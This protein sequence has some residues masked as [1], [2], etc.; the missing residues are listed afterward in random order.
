[1]ARKSVDL[2]NGLELFRNSLRIRFT[3]NGVRRSETLPFPTTQKGIKAASQLRDQVDNLIKLGLLDDAKYAELF[4]GSTVSLDGVPSFL[5]YAQSWL[6][7][8]VITAGTRKNYKGAL[9]LYWVPALA[10]IR[11]DMITTSL[12]RRVIGSIEWTSQ[13]VRRDAV[14]RLTTI[15]ESAL[16]EE[17]IK[18]NPAKAI[19]RPKR[20]RKEINP[21]TLEEANR[22]IDHLYE[23]I[24]WPSGI[25][26]AFFEFAFF[27][28][29]RLS[30]VAALRWDAVDLIKRQVH[31][32]RTVALGVVE[33][34]T[35]T[36]KDRFVLLNERALHALEFARQYAERRKKGVGKI[37]ELPY[38]F[39]PSKNSEYIR[40]TSDLHKQWGP[41]LKALEIPY[42]PPYNCRHTYATICLMSNMNPAFIAQ[43]LG[44]SVQMLLSTYARWLNSS[45]DWAEL[46]KLQ[47][48]IKSVS[49]KNDQL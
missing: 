3:W 25:Y 1:M 39:P 5:D 27:S 45:S 43:Q 40:Q 23:A 11:I 49:G 21:F 20:K 15:L 38:V 2:P 41:A 8:R 36:G 31:V 16:N 47:I 18:K 9:N 10:L 19:D 22:I 6:D 46:E 32:C 48:G 4:P 12:L 29:M 44:H 42:R 37:K 7:G 17:L 24:H 26:A 33:E 13:G 34:R 14:V 28:G 30:E 35:K